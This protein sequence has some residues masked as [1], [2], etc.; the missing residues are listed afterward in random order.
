MIGCEFETKE[1]LN[2]IELPGEKLGPILLYL[3]YFNQQVAPNPEE[4]LSRLARRLEGLSQRHSYT[5]AVCNR[6]W[7]GKP[8]ISRS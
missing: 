2:I 1:F 3:S 8:L 4:L 5:V 7:M 6:K